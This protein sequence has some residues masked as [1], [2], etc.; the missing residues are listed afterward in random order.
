MKHVDPRLT[1]FEVGDEAYFALSYEQ[2]AWRLP[3]N[4]TRAEREVVQAILDGVS[5]TRVAQLRGTSERT[6]ANLLARAFRKLGVQS[7]MELAARVSDG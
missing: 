4:L 6:I 7:R 2:P 3:A 5:R 1:M